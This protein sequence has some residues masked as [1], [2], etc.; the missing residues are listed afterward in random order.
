MENIFQNVDTDSFMMM[1]RNPQEFPTTT[2]AAAAAARTAKVFER[3]LAVKTLHN[4]YRFGH[5]RDIQNLLTTTTTDDD[6]YLIGLFWLPFTILLFFVLWNV[7]LCWCGCRCGCRRNSSSSCCR[8]MGFCCNTKLVLLKDEEDDEDEDD[9]NERAKDVKAKQKQQQQQQQSNNNT[10]T[11]TTTNNYSKN[12]KKESSSNLISA[13]LE[14]KKQIIEKRKRFSKLDSNNSKNNDNGGGGGSQEKLLSIPNNNNNNN[15]KKKTNTYNNKQQQQQSGRH[16]QQQKQQFLLL[17][18]RIRLLI[19]FCCLGIIIS[20]ILFTVMA[21]IRN[22]NVSLTMVKNGING[23]IQESV[24]TTTRDSIQV[25]YNT[26]LQVLSSSTRKFLDDLNPTICPGISTNFCTT[27]T[28]TTAMNSFWEC[29]FSLLSSS[30]SS[31][32]FGNKLNKLVTVLQDDTYYQLQEA[33]AMMDD[34]D[35]TDT[36]LDQIID[37]YYPGQYFQWIFWSTTGSSLLL[38]LVC[39]IIILFIITRI[40]SLNSKKK[41]KKKNTSSSSSQNCCWKFLRS[42]FVLPLLYLLS[43]LSWIY[44]IFYVTAAILISDFCY[45]SPDEP[46]LSLLRRQQDDFVSAMFN[47]LV[48]FVKGMCRVVIREKKKVFFI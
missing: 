47:Y 9:N 5:T 21:M 17:L 7:L 23:D 26:Q 6:D 18:Y 34:L 1:C 25:H 30:S 38:T 41:K 12:N 15:K 45:N 39:C 24:I 40:H 48:M 43:W 46:I 27:T 44:A 8:M 42:F 13:V 2:T 37:K 20:S 4:I 33:E 29:D 11:S 36:I 22:L 10:T 19:G 3:T 14:K 35:T 32:S 16:Q 28:T 31:L